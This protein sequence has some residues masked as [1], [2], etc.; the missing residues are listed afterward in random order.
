MQKSPLKELWR[1][2]K[3]LSKADQPCAIFLPGSEVPNWF[4]HQAIGSSI[5][6]HVPSLAEGEIQG[7]LIC[8]VYAAKDENK[9]TASAP[10]A[11]VNNK[12]R[13]HQET[14]RPT[15][16]PVPETCEDHY[17]VCHIPLKSY[18][19]EMESEEEIEVSIR[20]GHAIEV[21]KCGVHLLLVPNTINEYGSLVE[22]SHSETAA[23]DALDLIC[24]KRGRDDNEA[25][26]SN[27]TAENCSKR[28]RFESEA[29][30]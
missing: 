14:F 7:L 26:P 1:G 30:E 24:V 4:S 2:K 21:S 28:L 27:E 15:F 22:Y 23:E 20:A 16:R 8:A 3:G 11:I 5:S 18:G 17:C 10:F 6:F 25:G 9:A 12:T 13:G 19:F 29:Q